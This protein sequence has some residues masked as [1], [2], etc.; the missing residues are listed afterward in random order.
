MELVATTGPSTGS[1]HL[2]VRGE[3]DIATAPQLAAELDRVLAGEPHLV[4]LELGELS[5]LDCAGMRPVRHAL[6]DLRCRGGSLVIRHAPPLA[7]QALRLTGL[8]EALDRGPVS[9][10]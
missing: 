2:R 6:S 4:V 7:E 10:A 3:L 8:G 9:M 1:V 5:F